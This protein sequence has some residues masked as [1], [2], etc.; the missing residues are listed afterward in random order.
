MQDLMNLGEV[1]ENDYVKGWKESGGKVLGYACVTTPPEIIDAAGLLPYRLRAL[2]DSNTEIADAHLSR[3]NC[4]FCRSCL[5]LGLDGTL[6]LSRRPYRDK[7]LRPPARHVRELAVREPLAVLPLRQGA[8]PGR[9]RGHGVLRGGA[10]A[11]QAGDRGALRSRDHRRAPGRGEDRQDEIPREAEEYLPHAW[12]AA[13][14][15]RAP[16]SLALFLLASAVPSEAFIELADSSTARGRVRSRRLPGAPHARRRGD[17]RDRAAL[18]RLE[19]LGGLSSPTRCATGGALRERGRSPGRDPS[20]AWLTS[21]SRTC[22][23]RGCTTTSPGAATSSLDPV[24]KPQST[25][26]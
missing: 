5:Q 9:R 26:S 4:G 13:P 3:F 7:R 18:A 8:P 11:V 19:D 17:R 2:G 12:G 23:A 25:G 21:I 24:R 10:A 1:I 15:S 20:A 22:S 6:R 16:R 14:R